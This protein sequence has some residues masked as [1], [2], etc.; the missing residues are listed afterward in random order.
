MFYLIDKPVWFSSFDVIRKLRK[1]LNMK[2]IGHAG[3]LDPLA[4]GCLLIA[5]GNSTK[6]LPL[7]DGS[8]KTYIFSVRID[9]STPSLD[10]G[11][12]VTE[13]SMKS[14]TEK[15]PAELEEFL[16]QQTTQV[17]PQYSALHIW[18]ERAYDLA[19]KWEVFDIQPRQIQVQHVEILDFSPPLFT[20][21]L[22]ISSGWYIRSFAPVIG[23]FFGVSGGYVTA[24]RRTMIHTAHATL[25]ED[26]AI[27][28][29]D[30]D[31]LTP[32]PVWLLFPDIESLEIDDTTY[33]ELRE[34]R[35]IQSRAWLDGVIG[36]KY[37]MNYQNIYSS[38]VEYTDVGFLII[39][40]DI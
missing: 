27:Q 23:E 15:T 20:I 28:I 2:R 18:G 13:H 36:Q 21:E 10:L 35:T 34:G 31:A 16:L 30:L 17:P 32:L 38:L 40:N 4:S 7:L 37:F 8:E 11:T 19:R 1:A 6:L 26:M 12:E 25:R 24:L 3:T 5:T 22:R 29:D 14:Y 39:R 9:G 33:R